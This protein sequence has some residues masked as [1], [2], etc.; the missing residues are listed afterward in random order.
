MI[1]LVEVDGVVVSNDLPLRLGL[2]AHFDDVPRLVIKQ[3]MRVTLPGDGSK[4]DT[5]MS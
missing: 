1:E 3:A 5:K 2:Q 4:E